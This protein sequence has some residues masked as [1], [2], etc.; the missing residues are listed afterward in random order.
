MRSCLNS[1][2]DVL[3]T[4]VLK[5]VRYVIF[6]VIKGTAVK[7]GNS[8][9]ITVTSPL[10]TNRCFEYLERKQHSLMSYIYI[11]IQNKFFLKNVS[12]MFVQIMKVR[13]SVILVLYMYYYSYLELAFIYVLVI[14]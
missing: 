9:V 4:E 3:E 6:F 10:G 14:V 11:Y 8:L 1:E 7:S 5:Y 2:A 13:N 12:T